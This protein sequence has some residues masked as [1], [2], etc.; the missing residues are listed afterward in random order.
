MEITFSQSEKVIGK[1]KAWECEFAAQDDFNLHIERV[2]GGRFLVYQKSIEDGEYAIV[3]KLER[4]DD[5]KVIDLDMTALVYPKWIKIVSESEVTS[6]YLSTDGEVVVEGGGVDLS[7]ETLV[8][9]YDG[10]T[11]VSHTTILLE[12][13]IT[14]EPVGGTRIER[15]GDVLRLVGVY[16]STAF[17]RLNF[18]W[19]IDRDMYISIRDKDGNEIEP[20]EA[21]QEQLVFLTPYS[22]FPITIENYK[23]GKTYVLTI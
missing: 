19:S 9:F 14:L 18:P 10:T 16:P 12:N 15:D 13:A 4:Y 17:S 20:Y 11:W 3:D 1:K 7:Q 2:A 6:A 22:L 23:T 8:H 21:Y 5:N